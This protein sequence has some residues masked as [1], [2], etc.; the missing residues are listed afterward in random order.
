[1]TPHGLLIVDKQS[2]CTSHDV[3]RLARRAYGTRSVGH[4]GTL[5][6]MATGVLVLAI[7][8]AT[9]LVQYLTAAKK[10]YLGTVAFGAAT[11]TLDAEGAVTEQAPVPP[12]DSHTLT[13]TLQG[14]V[15]TTQ[16]QVPK[17]SAVRVG[18]NRLHELARRG[19][20]VTPPTRDVELFDARLVTHDS[21]SAQVELLVSKGFYVRSFARDWAEELGT[22]GHLTQLR[23]V[24][25]G[26]FGIED[27][28][29]QEALIA[30][31]EG[32]PPPGLISLPAACGFAGQVVLTAQGATDAQHGRPV[33]DA[34]G[35]IIAAP[36]SEHDVY[37]LVDAQGDLLALAARHEGG[38][39]ILRGFPRAAPS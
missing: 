23:R 12:L 16:Q 1:M 36:P 28:C 31:A 39:R 30:A 34:D 35:E 33:S 18:G 15:G 32:A 27:A 22:L 21:T 26:R 9:K 37:A 8:Q 10:R 29:P 2:G 7:G 13:D 11:H 6:P 25:S 19:V 24:Q 3:V 20:D 5:D 17:V 4:A 14:F 38:Y